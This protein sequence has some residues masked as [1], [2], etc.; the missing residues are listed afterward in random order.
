V[1]AAV[2]DRDAQ[3][4]SLLQRLT[5]VF[6]ELD[7]AARGHEGQFRDILT[8]LPGLET[9]L[10]GLLAATDPTLST[11]DADMP[12]I[13]RLLIQMAGGTWAPF[14]DGNRLM[15]SNTVT[16]EGLSLPPGVPPPPGVATREQVMQF[17]TGGR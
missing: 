15:V 10:R 13:Q 9:K 2:A 16:T 5:T 1:T 14:Q 17:L 7:A 4:R 12:S 8:R 3:L 11:I 6:D